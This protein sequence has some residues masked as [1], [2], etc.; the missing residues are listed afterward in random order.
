L[1]FGAVDVRACDALRKKSVFLV[2]VVFLFSRDL[3]V[4]AA[5]GRGCGCVS[6]SFHAGASRDSKDKEFSRNQ[7]TACCE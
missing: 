5:A 1:D 6:F 4:A 2:A 3:I 7:I